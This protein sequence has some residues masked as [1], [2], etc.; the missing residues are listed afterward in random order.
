MLNRL[1][2]STFYFEDKLVM[3]NC[4]TFKKYNPFNI[5]QGWVSLIIVVSYLPTVPADM[6]ETEKQ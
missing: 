5:T 1:I 4:K 2:I 6:I 3:S